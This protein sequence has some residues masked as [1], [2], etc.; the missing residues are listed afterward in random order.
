MAQV[1]MILVTLGFSIVSGYFTGLFCRANA[2]APPQVLFK[3]DDHFVNVTDRYPESF[4]D[5]KE[6]K[7]D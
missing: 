5:I 4:L 1:Y 2:F 3:D 6:G 7:R